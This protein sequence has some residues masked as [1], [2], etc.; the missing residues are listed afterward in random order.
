ME[1]PARPPRICIVG[2]G[3]SGAATAIQLVRASLSPLAIEIVEPREELGRG[4]AYTAPDPDWRLNGGID[5]HVTD[6]ADPGELIRWCA[7]HR[8]LESDL[9]ATA[10]NENV[11]VRRHDFGSFMR[12][13]VAA[14]ARMPNGSTIRHARDVAV[15]AQATEAI[16]TVRLQSGGSIEAD[17]LVIATGNAPARVPAAIASVARD[18]RVLA[19][20]LDAKRLREIPGDASVL[21]LGTGLTALDVAST[22]V[23]KGHRGRITAES[24]RG[25]RPRLHRLAPPSAGPT[26]LERIEG[27]VPAFVAAAGAP[28]TARA[29][30]RALRARIRDAEAEGS[31]WYAAFDDLR[32]VLW[33]V[34]PAMSAVEKR[35]A[36]RW[37]RPWYD[38][39][40]FRA[41][42]QNDALV[43]DAERRG[44]VVFR[45]GHVRA[46]E[47]R[48]DGLHV[49]ILAGGQ[50]ETIE[51]FDYLVNCTGLDAATGARDNPFLA[52]LL[53]RG[54]VTIDPTGVGFA[55]DAQCR[56]I[57]R[58]G[59]AQPRIRMIGPPTAGTFGDPLGV[60]FIAPQ[61]RRTVPS[62]LASLR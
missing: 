24:R 50:V 5:S 41:P 1:R 27:S 29:L 62:M 12:D 10:R 52:A 34:W 33:Q 17:L 25:L 30:L 31:S 2:G 13:Q 53:D 46:A 56:S 11:F 20:A 55:V 38:V 23:R 4:M 37:L 3:F 35:R 16:A 8:I 39:H 49:R 18:A 45:K 61:I 15:D 54:L 43:R 47:A 19:Q 26:L 36:L 51:R 59:H 32:D 44:I 14:H 6:L 28:P 21:L 60:L 7:A 57:D 48:A 42:P 22:L 40:R 9:D 58:A